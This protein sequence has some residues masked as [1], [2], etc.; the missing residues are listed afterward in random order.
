MNLRTVQPE[1]SGSLTDSCIA[2]RGSDELLQ[3]AALIQCIL[4][5]VILACMISFGEGVPEG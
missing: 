4:I 1:D 2:Q 5:L 3:S